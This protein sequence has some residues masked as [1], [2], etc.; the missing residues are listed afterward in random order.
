MPCC[1][2]AL[3]SA[4]HCSAHQPGIRRD[5]AWRGVTWRNVA[6]WGRRSWVGTDIRGFAL[7]VSGLLQLSGNK[8]GA[9]NSVSVGR[10]DGVQP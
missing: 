7:T 8:K 1:S 5:R 2:H 6:E 3:Q 9:N 10:T 4:L